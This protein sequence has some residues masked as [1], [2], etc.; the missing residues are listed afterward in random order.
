MRQYIVIA[1]ILITLFVVNGNLYAQ[2]QADNLAPTVTNCSPRAGS[3]QV[4]LDNI[5]N[6]HVT[7]AG[8]GVDANSV[9]IKVNGHTIYEGNKNQHASQNGH[10][11]RLGTKRDYTFV[12]QSDAAFGY[13]QT[14]MI[15]I[16]AKDFAG[17]ELKEYTYYIVTEMR[18]FGENKQVN[19]VLDA[20][21]SDKPAT[22]CDSSGNIWGV[23]HTGPPGSRDIYVGKLAA[24]A[25]DFSASVQ[26]TS[27]A[28]DQCNPAVALD[29]NDTL[30]VAW[31]D[32]RDGDWDIYA[33]TS[34]DGASWSAA[35]RVNDD[36]NDNQINPA[37]VIDG[38]SP[39]QAHLVWQ[40]D[41][42][43][44]QDICIA[45]S[46]DGFTTK[47]VSPI[48]T[49]PSDQVEPAV[50]ADAGNIIYV[51][52]TDGRNSSTD[53]YGA[54][55]NDGPW[56]NVPIVSDAN[57]QSSPVM[58]AESTGSILHLLWVDDTDPNGSIFYASTTDGLQGPLSVDPNVVDERAYAQR[59]PAIAVTGSTGNELR[60]FA[61]W[62]DWRNVTAGNTDTD[63]YFVELSS[64]SGTN[65]FVGDDGS[66]AYQSNPAVGIDEY[67]FPYLM[68][69]DD[70]GDNTDIYYAG[71]RFMDPISVASELVPY[72]HGAVIG[73][74]PGHLTKPG[75]ICIQVPPRAYP[76]DMRVQASQIKNPQ[77]FSA[78]QSEVSYEFGP[79]GIQFTV[80]ITITV[81]YEPLGAPVSVYWYDPLT[82][83]LRQDGI[84]NITYI[85]RP[86]V[87]LIRFKTRHFTPFY[88]VGG[89]PTGGG[90]GGGCSISPTGQGSITEFLL[91]YT[92]FVMVLLAIRRVDARKRKA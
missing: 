36:P 23:W 18:S 7:D 62:Q 16:T 66:N 72:S 61:C 84:T 28:N 64:G 90:G 51:V 78:T 85:E 24:G 35:T 45:T 69:A 32:D 12:Y 81:A 73:Q 8:A 25:D 44:N 60:V 48:T 5:I 65:I 67:G 57:N 40:D 11:R 19:S 33:S 41:R 59:Q 79:S 63:L 39:N 75:D 6:L 56:T 37:I 47:T 52:W 68:W 58:A 91:P 53:I 26:L 29:S 27:D 43:G 89:V 70:R 15:T 46:S 42:E 9:I 87:N 76:C 86:T 1:L 54:A 3:I 20:L 55:S 13:D 71:S 49:D 83:S 92:V 30:Y 31:Q 80:P 34:V 74:P 50:A 88:L 21:D 4:P 17:N 77:R 14:L 10:C 82:D 22:V 2:P 38:Q